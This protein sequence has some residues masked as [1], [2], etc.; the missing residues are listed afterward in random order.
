MNKKNFFERTI[1]I[2]A[3]Y[4]IISIFINFKIDPYGIFNKN[5]LNY[6]YHPNLNYV[7]TKYILENLNNYDSY[8][9][10]SSRV[11]TIPV[12]KLENAKFYNMSIS[13]GLPKEHLEILEIFLKNNL[14]I[15]NI[16][17]GIDIFSFSLDPDIHNSDFLRM[18][19]KYIKEN[20][21]Y[22]DY[23]LY[24]LVNYRKL[25]PNSEVTFD[26]KNTGNFIWQKKQNI[27]SNDNSIKLLERKEKTLNEIKQIIELGK[28]NHINIILLFTPSLKEEYETYPIEELEKIKHEIYK[29]NGIKIIDFSQNLEIINNIEYWYDNSH[30]TE[31][32][33]E[34]ILDEIRKNI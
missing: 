5:Y 28:E 23:L 15:K 12:S 19:F 33:G 30:T 10:G 9:F 11:G 2:I 7:K 24:P 32:A 8:L 14:K 27:N 26:I 16:I 22:I 3:I 4:F 21:K 18:T 25:I 34:I 31:K 1:I 20:N 6:K 17:L 29:I 13:S